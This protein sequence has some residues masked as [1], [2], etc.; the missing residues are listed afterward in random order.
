MESSDGESEPREEWERGPV[1]TGVR[2]EDLQSCPMD[3]GG[4]REENPCAGGGHDSG[5]EYGAFEELVGSPW[6]FGS[7]VSEPRSA[8]LHEYEVV[9]STVIIANTCSECKSY[10]VDPADPVGPRG[11]F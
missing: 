7:W 2:L 9:Y 1:G 4:V 11:A 5:L 6:G 10:T 3:R 8:Q